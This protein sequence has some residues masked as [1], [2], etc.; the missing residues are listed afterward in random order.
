MDIIVKNNHFLFFLRKIKVYFSQTRQHFF[1]NNRKIKKWMKRYNLARSPFDVVKNN[2][3]KTAHLYPLIV[4]VHGD[5]NCSNQFL[6]WIPIKF[7]YVDGYFNCSDNQIISLEFCPQKINGKF[8]CSTNQISNLE[9]CTQELDSL[10]I[11]Y[12]QLKSLKGCP[13]IVLNLNC[14]HNYLSSL[15][16][17]PEIIK[18]DLQASSNL[19]KNLKGSAKEIHGLVNLKDNP[20]ESLEYFPRISKAVYIRSR[21]LFQKMVEIGCLN[22][23]DE[24]VFFTKDPAFW[25]ELHLKAKEKEKSIRENNSILEHVALQPVN[26]KK[27]FKKI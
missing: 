4:N 27:S 15:E 17:S 19:I 13:H 24:N 3:E 8:N 10:D 9:Y 18:G 21:L 23:N 12:N 16:F 7:G 20:I 25:R 5:F 14:S 22:E 6:K 26:Q 1:K 11:S 2:D